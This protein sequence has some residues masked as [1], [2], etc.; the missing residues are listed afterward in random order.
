MT[1][2]ETPIEEMARENEITEKIIERL[3]E[4]AESLQSDR[5]VPIAEIR[6][7]IRLLQQ[8]H[9][10]HAFRFDHDLQPAARGVAMPGCY[11]HL[12]RITR[13][14]ASDLKAL[15]E[16]VAQFPAGG[17]VTISRSFDLGRQLQDRME[18]LHDD[19]VYEG[20]YP[21]SCLITALPD[22]TEAR[23]EEKFV[24]NHAELARLEAAIEG[25]LVGA[26]SPAPASDSADV[27]KRGESMPA[28]V[29]SEEP[30]AEGP[31]ECPCCNPI[32]AEPE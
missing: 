16:L 1:E 8:Y 27:R 10:L 24:V 6:T 7:G 3:A 30:P 19:I 15:D 11:E 18:R 22:A 4:M 23:I 17:V 32:S 26:S 12:D 5:P 20:D 14:H 13:D 9:Q 31:S 21:L 2:E 28:H 29:G 25:F